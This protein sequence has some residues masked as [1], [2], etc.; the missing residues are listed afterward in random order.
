MN[1]EER[2]WLERL[3]RENKESDSELTYTYCPFSVL[4]ALQQENEKLKE[5]NTIY[6]ST[7]KGQYNK[8]KELQNAKR[9]SKEVHKKR[10]KKLQ[11]ESQKLKEEILKLED[12]YIH[13]VPC[14]N[15]E[16]CEFYKKYKENEA[17][18]TTVYLKGYEDGKE[19]YNHYKLLYQ[20]VKDRVDA[21]EKENQQLK[22]QLKLVETLTC[23]NMPDNMP[24][25][26]MFKAD[27]ERNK[28]EYETLDKYKSALDEIRELLKET[29]EYV[30]NHELWYE[31]NNDFIY[32][33]NEMLEILKG[34]E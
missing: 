11:E 16:D 15:E 21:V 24:M 25:V 4:Y 19:K 8:I 32:C 10:N 17:D 3:I 12:K 9:I 22:E 27:Y 34:K 7:I 1:K 6:K 18:L 14:C 2:E 5:K 20:K 29:F 28:Y 31:R 23:F 33:K 26:C 30:E 13:N